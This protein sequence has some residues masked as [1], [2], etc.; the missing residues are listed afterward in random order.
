MCGY[1]PFY[2]YEKDLDEEYIKEQEMC[3]RKLKANEIECRVAQCKQSGCSL[4]LYK[5]ARVDRSILDEYYG[6]LWQNDF[7]TIDGK[8]YGG[9][10]IY[11]KDL[12]QWLWRWDCGTE[13]NTEAEKGQASDCF[14][15]AGFKWGIGVELYTAPFI[16]I[17]DVEIQSYNGK[18]KTNDT[19]EVS[20]IGYSDIGEINKLK[21]INAKTKKVVYEL[22]KFIKAE[23]KA[24]TT[25]SDIDLI[26]GLKACSDIK[27]LE[28]Y[29][30]KYKDKVTNKKEFNKVTREMQEKLGG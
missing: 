3:I 14:K 19:F 12:N 1:D 17:T 30:N 9:I 10:G 26:Q 29:Y 27:N 7:K 5:T 8:M 11:N 13:S 6:D 18:Y 4:L 28:L 22:G 23:P 2:W 20:E 24:E 25:T 21:I 15:R 16:W